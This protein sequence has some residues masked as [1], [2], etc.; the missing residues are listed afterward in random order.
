MRPWSR[1]RLP[2]SSF[3]REPETSRRWTAVFITE[4]LEKKQW[5]N[6]EPRGNNIAE[7]KWAH[8]STFLFFLGLCGLSG[9]G[10]LASCTFLDWLRSTVFFRVCFFFLG[11][12]VWHVRRPVPLIRFGMSWDVSCSPIRCRSFL[13]TTRFTM[14]LVV[15]FTWMWR[16]IGYL[17]SLGWFLLKRSGTHG[18][19][20]DW[21]CS[22]SNNFRAVA[23]R[24]V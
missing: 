12:R 13:E 15:G 1:W 10:S 16:D 14:W 20:W 22:F 3:W 2:P 8:F 6:Y 4:L 7:N 5:A 11:I 24:F 18:S 21:R 23:D 17:D 19:I 9:S